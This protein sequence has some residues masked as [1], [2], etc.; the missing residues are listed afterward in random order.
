MVDQDKPHSLRMG[1][2][3]F[4]AEM[5]SA[6]PDRI[7]KCGGRLRCV[8]ITGHFVNRSKQHE[9]YNYQCGSCKFS[10]EL[11]DE[12]SIKSRKRYS[13]I[14]IGLVVLFVPFA[15]PA[16]LIEFYGFVAFFLCVAAFLFYSSKRQKQLHETFPIAKD[17]EPSSA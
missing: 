15:S 1:K 7:C 5:S 13:L 3:R 4:L 2:E 11:H 17:S 12:K 16:N 14:C 6:Q 9:A 10:V 8:H